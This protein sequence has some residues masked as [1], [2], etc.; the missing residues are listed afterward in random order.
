[1]QEILGHV[2]DAYAMYAYETAVVVLQSIDKVQE[3][4]RAK[5]IEGM[6][7]TTEF[8]S[9]LG[10]SWSFTETGD[11]SSTAMGLNQVQSGEIVYLKAIG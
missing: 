9:L 10:G 3:K 11:T 5:M 2:P 8:L 6:L 7:S 4:D 1:M